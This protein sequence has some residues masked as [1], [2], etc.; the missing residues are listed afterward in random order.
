M[1]RDMGPSLVVV[2]VVVLVVEAAHEDVEGV[3]S[4]VLINND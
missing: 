1:H 3:D 2:R 4:L